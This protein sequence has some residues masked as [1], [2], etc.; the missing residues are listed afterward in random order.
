MSGISLGRVTV[1]LLLARAMTYVLGVANS[2]VLARTLGVDQLGVYAYAVGLAGLFALLPNMGIGTIVTRAVARDPA[3]AAALVPTA[4]RAQGLLAVGV[5]IGAPALAAALPGHPAPWYHVALAAAQLAI[6]TL[7]W[8]YL[9]V[10]GGHARY[11]RLAVAELLA[12]GVGT[13]TLVAAATLHGGVGQ[14][15]SA[16]V[17]AAVVA[18]LVARRVAAPFIPR[19]DGD[20]LALGTLLR[21]GAPLG[22]TAAL[23]G[24]YTRLDVLLLGQLASTVALGLYNVAYKP[25]NLA[26]YFG[27]AIAGTLLPLMAQSRGPTPP[28]A[29]D[30]ALRGLAAAGPALALIL[31]GLGG[32]LL[33]TLYGPEFEAAAPVLG[34]LAWSAVAN[35]LYAPLGVALQARGA[36]RAWLACM[37]A[38]LLV[39]AAGNWWA[40]PRWG[41]L[42]A[43]SATLASEVV[44]FGLGLGLTRW[45]LQ[46]RVSTR[47][48][49]AALGATAVGGAVLW[50]GMPIEVASATVAALAVY[51]SL[52]LLFRAV[53]VRDLKLVAGWVRQAAVGASGA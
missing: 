11:D 47:P 24:V 22:A 37:A 46:L 12:G 53:T 9:A 41:A 13:A 31:T 52:L 44:L 50:L 28:V 49:L 4:L 1:L 39:N 6:G 8:P 40:I 17:A 36:E 43:A 35:W 33:R 18:V 21:R 32:A 34:V 25:V 27:A 3:A 19:R 10:L 48:V 23:Q 51:G 15:L 2:V 30:R 16:Q 38:G 20:A 42:G 26:V 45:R 7:S 14:F 5:L 29:F